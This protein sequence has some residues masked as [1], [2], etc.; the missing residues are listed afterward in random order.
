MGLS[1]IKALD[2]IA[3][4]IRTSATW[5]CY[6]TS[7][8]IMRT[9]LIDVLN[10][11]LFRHLSISSAS[12]SFWLFKHYIS[13]T[14]S[15][16]T[17]KR[18]RELCLD[19]KFLIEISDA[20]GSRKWDIPIK[21]K[22]WNRSIEQTSCIKDIDDRFKHCWVN[23]WISLP[24]K[25]SQTPVISVEWRSGVQASR[26]LFWQ[27]AYK[28]LRRRT[29]WASKWEIRREVCVCSRTDLTLRRSLSLLI[30]STLAKHIF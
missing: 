15:S 18:R 29:T 30:A 2:S 9:T 7:E 24:I 11:Y 12:H 8:V 27:R 6:I 4:Q 1:E 19:V 22:S 16:P 5:V 21:S 3:A 14:T 10:T 17:I 26:A 25:P 13:V 23:A 28:F 20:I